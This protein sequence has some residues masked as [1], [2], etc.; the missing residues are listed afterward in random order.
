MA[1][2]SDKPSPVTIH[3]CTLIEG[4]ATLS[5][6]GAALFPYWSFTKT[7]IAICALRLA[8]NSVVDLDQPLPGQT[9]SLA[10]LLSHDA[11]LP[12]YGQ[13]PDYHRAVAAGDSPWSPAE[14]LERVNHAELAVDGWHYSNIGY[15]LARGHIEDRAHRPLNQ[16][17]ADLICRPLGLTS[18]RLVQTRQDFATLLWPEAADYDPAWVYHGCLI[19]TAGDAAHLLAGLMQGK[20][21][22][23]ASLQRMLTAIPVGGALPGRPWLTCNYGLGL[24]I[25]Q[26]A[27]VG[28]AIGHT[29]GGP[30][31]VNAVYHFPELPQPVTVASFAHGTDEGKAEDRVALLAANQGAA[32]SASGS[33]AEASVSGVD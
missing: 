30:F 28:L 8:E 17:I 26:M 5:G 15:M 18:V 2:A 11:G 10:A 6:D 13:L 29:G 14:M 22:T 9:F 24:M 21:L 1:T 4:A 16:L 25:G 31:C 20:L 32:G 12:D 33:A 27:G 19:G 3:S 23:P 7:A